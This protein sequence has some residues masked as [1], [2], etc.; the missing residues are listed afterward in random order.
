MNLKGEKIQ[1]PSNNGDQLSILRKKNFQEKRGIKGGKKVCQ[2]KEG[3]VNKTFPKK[4]PKERRK[5]RIPKGTDI[6]KTACG[7]EKR[8]RRKRKRKKTVKPRKDEKQ[9]QRR[10]EG[11][12]TSG[13]RIRWS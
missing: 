4:L 13:S 3:E 7:G 10:G 1:E 11:F 9:Q 8:Q 2:G 12:N 6:L 5:G